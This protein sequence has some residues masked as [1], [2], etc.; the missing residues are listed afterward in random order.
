[1][2]KLNASS[3]IA[4]EIFNSLNRG[5][6][7]RCSQSAFCLLSIINS[8]VKLSRI[9]LFSAVPLNQAIGVSRKSSSMIARS[10]PCNSGLQTCFFQDVNIVRNRQKNNFPEVR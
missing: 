9:C 1:M 7:K 10:A 2:L 5:N 4:L 8:A 3:L 6:C